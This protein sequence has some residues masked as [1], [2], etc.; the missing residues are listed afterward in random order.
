MRVQ[1]HHGMDPSESAVVCSYLF[2]EMESRCW[3]ANSMI[4]NVWCLV[5]IPVHRS[6]ILQSV[7]SS[8]SHI[9]FRLFPCLF[10]PAMLFKNRNRRVIAASKSGTIRSS[11]NICIYHDVSIARVRIR[12]LQPEESQ[13]F[14][15]RNRAGPVRHPVQ[16]DN[17]SIQ[18]NNMWA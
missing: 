16:C 15:I 2:M 6:M 14:F 8:I 1:R 17:A 7:H 9:A 12:L 5:I 13:I 3:F 18:P 4:D 11:I 10:Y